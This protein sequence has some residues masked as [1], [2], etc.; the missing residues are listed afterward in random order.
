MTTNTFKSMT[1]WMDW[2]GAQFLLG[3]AI[4]LWD[5]TD[6]ATFC[7]V[8]HMFWTNHPVGNSLYC[9]LEQLVT[10]GVLEFRDEPS[11]QFRWNSNLDI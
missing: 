6:H 5:S 3:H 9:C 8:K 2:D 4:G 7:R 10:A 11:N 1:E